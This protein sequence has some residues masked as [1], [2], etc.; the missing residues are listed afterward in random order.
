M[1]RCG[2]PLKILGYWLVGLPTINEL[3]IKLGALVFSGVA[4]LIEVVYQIFAAVATARLFSPGIID[5]FARRVQILLSIIMVFFVMINLFKFIVDP[6]KLTSNSTESGKALLKNVLVTIVL[7]ATV[8]FLFDLAYD[9]QK[10]V[11]SDDLIGKIFFADITNLETNPN[12]SSIP[13][14][15]YVSQNLAETMAAGGKSMALSIFKAFFFLKT[16]DANT[17]G[18]PDSNGQEITLFLT[19]GNGE[20]D[21]KTSEVLKTEGTVRAIDQLYAR[22]E[23]HPLDE[24]T[25]PNKGQKLG[26]MWVSR[27]EC[28]TI[29]NV[30]S[31]YW[32]LGVL[33]GLVA[34][35]ILFVYSIDLGIRVVKLGFYQLIAPVPI[36]FRIIPKKKSVYDNWLKQ[37]INTFVEVFIRLI[38]V[39]FAVFA[40]SIVALMFDSGSTFSLWEAGGPQGAIKFFAIALIMLGIILFMKQAPKL[41]SDVLGIDSGGGDLG[42]GFGK[43]KSNLGAGKNA[44]KSVLGAPKKAKNAIGSAT[45]KVKGAA[46]KVGDAASKAGNTV[47]GGAQGIKNGINHWKNSQRLG[48]KAKNEDVNNPNPHKQKSHNVRRA[49]GAVNAARKGVVAGAK[50]GYKHQGTSAELSGLLSGMAEATGAK[51]RDKI[52]NAYEGNTSLI[53]QAMRD[54]KAKRQAAKNERKEDNAK[55]FAEAKKS[56]FAAGTQDLSSLKKGEE[57]T[58][59]AIGTLGAAEKSATTATAPFSSNQ[60]VKDTKTEMDNVAAKRATLDPEKA[61][62]QLASTAAASKLAQLKG[63]QETITAGLAQTENLEQQAQN[64]VAQTK[65]EV[66]RLNG[67]SASASE[68]RRSAGQKF[69]DKFKGASHDKASVKALASSKQNDVKDKKREIDQKQEKLKSLNPATDSAEIQ[70]L[71]QDI[72]ADRY[73]LAELE[74]EASVASEYAQT[75]EKESTATKALIEAK[76]AHTKSVISAAPF[77]GGASAIQQEVVSLQQSSEGANQRK[78]SL[79]SNVVQNERRQSELQT[80]LN[81]VVTAIG[82]SNLVTSTSDISTDQANLDALRSSGGS[83]EQIEKLDKVIKIKQESQ[84]IATAIKQDK[85]EILAQDEIISSNDI[86]IS[87]LQSVSNSGIVFDQNQHEQ[88]VEII[89]QK[90]ERA[91]ARGDEELVIHLQGTKSILQETSGG[92]SSIKAKVETQLE[93]VQTTAAATSAKIEVLRNE[94]TRI[95]STVSPE[96]KNASTE[97]LAGKI[98]VLDAR[99]SELSIKQFSGTPLTAEE[100]IEYSNIGT[101]KEKIQNIINVRTELIATEQVQ[102]KQNAEISGLQ[103]I[104]DSQIDAGS[105]ADFKAKATQKLG[106]ISTEVTE[107]NKVINNSSA[108]ITQYENLELEERNLANTLDAL[109]T[110]AYQKNKER[111]DISLRDL[112]GTLGKI[113]NPQIQEEIT[114]VFGINFRDV[115]GDPVSLD[116]Q[117]TWDKLTTPQPIYNS[118]GSVARNVSLDEFISH[119]L[120][121]TQ[122]KN[123]TIKK[124]IEILEGQA[125]PKEPEKPKQPDKPKPEDKKGS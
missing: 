10:A 20:E 23:G 24:D 95:E 60:A 19:D 121:D 15:D 42:F 5:L 43:L 9:V 22:I 86:T 103:A 33:A 35:Y 57:A 18:R 122:K 116:G 81:D 39:Y 104:V 119:T 101:E 38:I 4:Y 58:G 111:I 75:Q 17:V 46:K 54:A 56:A 84:N 52:N 83:S 25:G 106:T 40:I 102:E 90:I 107:Q 45:N 98:S 62:A 31:F 72:T 115:N 77:S 120:Q 91:K 125:K 89:D 79:S 48:M 117:I 49:F 69:S 109:R 76:A 74:S 110:Q 37:T 118:D 105:V 28:K 67:E 123:A 26:F 97:Q 94:Q 1:G 7:L 63:Q 2:E 27:L 32:V 80:N 11:L 53:G 14:Q 65:N 100:T 68:K 61:K 87:N 93:N 3:L 34:V 78:V 6:D 29:D 50:A 113:S 64:N 96:I 73:S 88:Q 21:R 114:K 70:K 59:K 36:G 108:V 99:E 47:S 66:D 13:D 8:G 112:E 12:V 92:K 30:V 55:A 44:V 16:D 82:D 124:Q 51:T 41:L 71:N 85:A